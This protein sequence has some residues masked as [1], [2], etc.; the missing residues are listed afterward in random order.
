MTYTERVMRAAAKAPATKNLT[1][2][3]HER[4]MH[5][6]WLRMLAESTGK[7]SHCHAPVE[8]LPHELRGELLQPQALVSPIKGWIDGMSLSPKKEGRTIELSLPGV[9]GLFKWT[10]LAEARQAKRERETLSG[11]PS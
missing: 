8:H 6:K 7:I 1:E 5:A 2:A 4:M 9:S 10:Y 3:E 11:A